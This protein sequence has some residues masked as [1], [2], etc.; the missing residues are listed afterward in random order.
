MTNSGNSVLVGGGSRRSGSRESRRYLRQLQGQNSGLDVGAL[1]GGGGAQALQEPLPPLDL[2]PIWE[3]ADGLQRGYKLT[4]NSARGGL[5][6]QRG[7]IEEGHLRLSQSSL[8]THARDEMILP[9]KTNAQENAASITGNL[10]TAFPDGRLLHTKWQN[11]EIMAPAEGGSWVYAETSVSDPTVMRLRDYERSQI[12]CLGT[13]MF[14]TYENLVIMARSGAVFARSLSAT[15]YRANFTT[16][17]GKSMRGETF[18]QSPLPGNPL[19]VRGASASRI[20]LIPTESSTGN[21][22]YSQQGSLM[23]RGVGLGAAQAI[24]FLKPRNLPPAAYWLETNKKPDIGSDSYRSRLASTNAYGHD[25]QVH[26]L[27]MTRIIGAS[28]NREQGGIGLTDG[29]RV[30]FWDGIEQDLGIFADEPLKADYKLFCTG[31]SSQEGQL[32]AQINELPYVSGGV[33]QGKVRACKRRYDFELKKWSQV[34]EWL[35]LVEDGLISW[36]TGIPVPVGRVAGGLYGYMSAY[37]GPDLPFGD[38]TRAMH[39]YAVQADLDENLQPTIPISASYP[40]T[41][42]YKFQEPAAT[43]PYGLRDGDQNFAASGLARWPALIWPEGTEYADKYLDAV[44][45]GGQDTGGTGSK[46]TVR[47]GEGGRMD[48][49]LPGPLHH[50]FTSPVNQLSRRHFWGDNQTA[51]LFPQIEVE[52]TRGTDAT[53]TPQALP[54]TLYFHVNFPKPEAPRHGWLAW[55]RSKG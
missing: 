35:T 44:Y 5:E 41:W 7:R 32:F 17:D 8:I 6:M 20:M 13:A 42:S 37:G 9:F 25:Y 18:I 55:G 38:V 43:N 40:S 26:N 31:L 23:L 27:S 46:V 24:G 15:S 28:A 14:G 1:T 19:I 33:A 10:Q 3:S 52:I 47:V 21:A 54:L 53:K 48:E 50:V 49:T 16:T 45:W 34:S 12:T 29:F 2:T 36:S 22:S 4:I 11:R 51:L 39:D 30:V